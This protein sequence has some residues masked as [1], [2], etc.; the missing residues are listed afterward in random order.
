MGREE[1]QEWDLAGQVQGVG[2][3]SIYGEFLLSIAL[4]HTV[5]S[6]VKHPQFLDLMYTTRLVSVM[7]D[8]T[9]LPPGVHSAYVK[10]YDTACPDKGAI[11]E[12]PI[13]VVVPGRMVSKVSKCDL[14]V[15]LGERVKKLTER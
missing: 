10:G 12:I 11:F 14:K 4:H 13:H 2:L 9:S 8:P 15:C 7:V 1:S 5:V 3:I 6:W